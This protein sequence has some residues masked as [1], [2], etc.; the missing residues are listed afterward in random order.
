M[1]R[2]TLIL[3]LAAAFRAVVGHS[4]DPVTV[5]VAAAQVIRE[6]LTLPGHNLGGLTD[7]KAPKV[8]G[9]RLARFP[10]YPTAARAYW[11]VLVRCKALAAFASGDVMRSARV[12][13]KCGYFSAP[14]ATYQATWAAVLDEI[15]RD[16]LRRRH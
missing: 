14:I 10:N 7:R 12:L 5:D 8:H 2:A 16:R 13:R 6:G 11:R 9:I 15:R 3:L 1:T 4:P